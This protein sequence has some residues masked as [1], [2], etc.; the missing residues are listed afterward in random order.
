MA[1]ARAALEL[2]A[3]EWVEVRSKE[4][5]LRTL[6]ANGCLDGQPFMP[7]MLHYC[8]K[9]FP[10]W[11]AAH[12]TCDTINATGGRKLRNTV[13]LQL[14]CDGSAHGGCDA[15][16]LIFWNEAW[17]KRAGTKGPPLPGSADC[18]EADLHRFAQA[19]AQDGHGP[20]YR[21][22][23]TELLNATDALPW[24]DLRQYFMDVT[25]GNH[26]AGHVLR[27]LMLG[28]FRRLV[29]TGHGYR[30]LVGAYNLVQKWRGG[31]PYP[32]LPDA[33]PKGQPTPTQSFHLAPGEWVRIKSHA[34]I[35][36][37]TTVNGF[38]RGMRFDVEMAKYCGNRYRV[39]KRV[40]KIIN[41]KTGRMM[42][43]K[44]PCIIL[45]DVYCRAECTPGRLGC[46]RAVNTY[47]REIWLERTEAPRS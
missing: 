18:T 26:H 9:R 45:E 14:R 38:N 2:H 27:I 19:P 8:G 30:L 6:D 3:G 24:W 17:L 1:E 29:A 12:K 41:E 28:A 25:S 22:Q 40:G 13:H 11:K 15:G 23:A 5:I 37:T 39:K 36:A 44:Y 33:I 20:V 34:E 21:C 35:R 16:C 32:D 47:W 7:E 4:E 46:P 10:V 43:M 31:A 42:H